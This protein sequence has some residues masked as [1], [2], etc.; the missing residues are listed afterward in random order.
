M[1]RDIR[2]EGSRK[3]TILVLFW[4]LDGVVPPPGPH[5]VILDQNLSAARVGLL[6]LR[7]CPLRPST[8]RFS[9]DI[10]KSELLANYYLK[11]F[12]REGVRR[13]RTAHLSSLDRFRFRH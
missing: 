5:F 10:E 9:P 3:R 13:P 6:A 1:C 12:S 2:L 7:Q 11:R 8:F 4:L